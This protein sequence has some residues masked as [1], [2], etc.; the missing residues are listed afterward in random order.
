MRRIIIAGAG[1]FGRSAANLLNSA[2]Y[3][4][5]AFGDNNP[6][7][8]GSSYSHPLGKKIPYLSIE[9]A[10]ALNPDAVMIGVI[11]EVRTKQLILQIRSIGF[12]G[13]IFPL[14]NDYAH[15]DARSSTLIRIA[16]RLL[17]TEPKET[18]PLPSVAE[19]GVYKGDLA[20]QIN[21]L[22]PDRKLFLF[23]TFDGFDQR[24]VDAERTMDFSKACTGDF[25]D[26]SV[27][28]V[29]SRLPH[30]K[31]ACFRKGFFPDTAAGLENEAFLLVSL[32]AD[33]YQ[34]ILSG[35]EF[36]WPRLV[37]GGVILLHDYNN[38]RFRGAGQAV[39][40]YERKLGHPLPLI[41]LCDL[42]GTA[43]IIRS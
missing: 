39:R 31:S 5:I 13:E 28:F 4:L 2:Y 40:E 16:K 43:V 15:L 21:A 22:F 7:L 11:D 17:E 41:P 38:E 30:P 14:R 25:S 23:D 3:D 33:L 37:P 20:W 24:D 32:D 9:D 19:L 35:L 8:W 36:F 6:S 27:E 12:Q 18:E 26:T 29:R 10:L 34:P 42:H 1:Q